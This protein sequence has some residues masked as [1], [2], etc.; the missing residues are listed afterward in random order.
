MACMPGDQ[1]PIGKN[2]ST[3]SAR[4]VDLLHILELIVQGT[5]VAGG[6]F[7]KNGR[8]SVATNLDM[9]HTNYCN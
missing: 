5:T 7:A 6:S 8:K 9:L 3:N 2:G 4:S 1:R